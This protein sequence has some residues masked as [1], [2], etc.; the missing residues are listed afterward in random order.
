MNTKVDVVDSLNKYI[1]DL[2]KKFQKEK[3][4]NIED[5]INEFKFNT[6]AFD[7]NDYRESMIPELQ[8]DLC[9]STIMSRHSPFYMYQVHKG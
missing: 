8:K 4:K 7:G 2:N 3:N 5:I 9:E 1:K 6:H